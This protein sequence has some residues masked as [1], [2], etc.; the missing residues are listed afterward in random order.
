MRR[1]EGE[2]S[3]TTP[4][5]KSLL[6]TLVIK[7]AEPLTQERAMIR[8]TAIEKKKVEGVDNHTLSHK[9]QEEALIA[10]T[11]KMV[12]LPDTTEVE[13]ITTQ[14]VKPRME[15]VV[16]EVGIGIVTVLTEVVEDEDHRAQVV[17][18]IGDLK[19]IGEGG[20]KEE[21]ADIETKQTGKKLS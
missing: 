2:H 12:I 8:V 18:R 14:I 4:R 1:E 6:N 3:R 20:E 7:E 5:G 10:I 21:V 17:M 9:T 19:G 16:K 11:E 13:L 15:V